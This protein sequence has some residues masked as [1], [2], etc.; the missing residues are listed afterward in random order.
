MQLVGKPWDGEHEDYLSWSD[1]EN[2]RSSVSMANRRKHNKGPRAKK[3]EK[4]MLGLE[5][6]D[7]ATFASVVSLD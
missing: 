5:C 6:L 1:V 4:V 2:D 3:L 7:H